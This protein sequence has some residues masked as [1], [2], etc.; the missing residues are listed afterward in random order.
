MPVRGVQNILER[1]APTWGALH[2]RTLNPHQ[3]PLA[4]L[5]RPCSSDGPQMLLPQLYLEVSGAC[6]EISHEALEEEC[7]MWFQLSFY[8]E[9]S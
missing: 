9:T 8:P 4:G 5:V 7:L 1:A 3:P 2:C 6:W